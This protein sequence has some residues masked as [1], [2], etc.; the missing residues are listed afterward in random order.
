MDERAALRIVE[1]VVGAAGDDAA[2]VDDQ[3]IAVDM[4]HA[5]ADLPAGVTPYTA[6]WRVIAVT[7]SDLAAMGAVPTATLSV[8]SP[9]QFDRD[10]LEA[11]LSGAI[12]ATQAAGAEYV[13]GDLD[14]TDELITVGMAL[15]TAPDPV[16]RHGATPGDAVVVTGTLGRGAIAVDR[17][18]AGEVETANELFRVPPR[19]EA[20]KRLAVD[21]TAMID[22]SDGL[23]RSLH[24]LAEASD[25]GMA[26]EA[27]S[28]PYDERLDPAKHREHG[29]YWGEDFELIATVPADA[30][31][32]IAEDLEVSLSRIGTVTEAGVTIDGESLPDRGY[33]HE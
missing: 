17:F 20:G 26:I 1:S 15:G 10:D 2:V 31:D 12:D 25:C 7:I 13:G 21:A 16:Y 33:T 19:I 30:I 9:P 22:S 29:I 28:L 23:A 5:S 27:S 3:A 32:D 18:E 8:Y 11:Y 4:L 24:L 14:I 6:G